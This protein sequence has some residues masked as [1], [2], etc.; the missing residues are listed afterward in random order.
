M[1]DIFALV[2]LLVLIAVSI[3]IIVKLGNLPGNLAKANGHPQQ[4]AIQLLGWI[5]LLTLGLGWFAALVWAKTKSE[6]TES[7]VAKRVADL[8]T[9]LSEIKGG[10]Q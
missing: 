1:L 2:V 7:D 8:E 9:K 4:E 10:Q 5:G 6:T 3:F